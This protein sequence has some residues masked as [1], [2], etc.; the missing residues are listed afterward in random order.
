MQTPRVLLAG[1]LSIFT[2]S[3]FADK[4]TEPSSGYAFDSEKSVAGKSYTLVG[5]GMRKKFIVKVYAMGMYV[6]TTDAKRAFSS[7]ATKAGGNDQA[8]LAAGDKAQAFIVNGTFDKIGVLHFVRD[9]DAAKVRE[10]FTEGLADEVSDKAAPDVREAAQSFLKLVD[11]DL[12]N[13]DDLVIHSSTDGRLEI[14]IGGQDKGGVTNAKLARA[15]W[16]VWLG[17]KPVTKDLKGEL[18]NRIEQ[19]GK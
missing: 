19:L 17:S 4:I 13:G 7:L 11:R 3:A 2:T 18:V 8:H 9:V 10:A 16:S 15:M 1:L 12:K 14:S 6:E 5:V